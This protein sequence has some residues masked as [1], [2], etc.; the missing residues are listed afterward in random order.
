MSII[1]L[2]TFSKKNQQKEMQ[3]IRQCNP[4]SEAEI[5]KTLNG[6]YNIRVLNLLFK[7]HKKITGTGKN[8]FVEIIKTFFIFS[9]LSGS[10]ISLMN[11]IC[12]SF[13]IPVYFNI[14]FDFIILGF[15]FFTSLHIFMNDFYLK[16]QELILINFM[17][18][19][20][21]FNNKE[22]MTTVI[23]NIQHNAI[24]DEINAEKTILNKNITTSSKNIANKQK[25]RI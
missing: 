20:N 7:E 14:I 1:Y 15:A 2:F 6:I 8:Y 17:L 13:N 19:K 10:M 9:M 25:N 21:K 4:D 24:S 23:K 11:I 18:N 16:R 3:K 12:P 5:V 22:I